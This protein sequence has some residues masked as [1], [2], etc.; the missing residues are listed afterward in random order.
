MVIK[1][2]ELCTVKG[3]GILVVIRDEGI[4]LRPE[5]SGGIAGRWGISL[6]SFM[7]M[8]NKSQRKRHILLKQQEG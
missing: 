5:R 6:S 7:M 4:L 8:N 3:G 1:E 2:F